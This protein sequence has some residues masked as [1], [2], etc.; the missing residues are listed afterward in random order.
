MTLLL[1][2]L[3]FNFSWF[4]IVTTAPDGRFG[5]WARCLTAG[6]SLLLW[7]GV[8]VSGRAIAFF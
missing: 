2:T 4:R 6:V 5:P 8:G 1:I 7:F 3:I